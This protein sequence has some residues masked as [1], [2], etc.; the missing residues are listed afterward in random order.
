PALVLGSVILVASFFAASS[1]ILGT[2]WKQ[3]QEKFGGGVSATERKKS[4][5]ELILALFLFFLGMGIVVWGRY[6]LISEI[7]REKTILRGEG[8]DVEDILFTIGA[9]LGNVGVWV[10]AMWWSYTKHDSIPNF[11][12][13]RTE[14]ERLQAKMLRLYEKY[15][16]SRNQRHILAGR[17]KVEQLRR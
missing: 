2:L 11:S 1:H 17:K 7:M 12:E 5:L 9:I 13:L 3:R 16:T 15:L 14:V 10:A 8:L 6:L 4:R